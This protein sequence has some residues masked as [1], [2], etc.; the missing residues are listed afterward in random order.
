MKN[1]F[2]L[3]ELLVVIAIIAILASMLLPALANARNA[4]K[5]TGCTNQLKQQGLAFCQYANDNND[6]IAVKAQTSADPWSAPAS[7]SGRYAWANQIAIYLI[8]GYQDPSVWL[9]ATE[10]N[11]RIFWCPADPLSPAFN[12]EGHMRGRLSYGQAIN[13]G[14]KGY[15]MTSP[16]LKSPSQIINVTDNLAN[17]GY[18][19][20]YVSFCGSGCYSVMMDAPVNPAEL[21]H[22]GATNVLLLDGHVRNTTF[23]ALK[24]GLND[25][26]G[27]FW[28]VCRIK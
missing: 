8:T 15:K 6:Y 20:S 2:T 4:G 18:A 7:W 25:T 3:I 21:R 5:R 13:F 17:S 16:D 11:P 28:G 24:T 10:W 26:Y 27:G 19:H 12:W 1:R 14:R 9:G 23:G 22:S